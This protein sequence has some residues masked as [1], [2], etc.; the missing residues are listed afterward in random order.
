MNIQ[1]IVNNL[2]F[3]SLA[4]QVFAPIIFSVVDI[5]TGFIQAVI[6]NN[7]SSKV[8]RVGL[9]HKILI[10]IVITTGFVGGMAFNLPII[11][12]FIC[13]YIIIMET[14]SIFENLSKA[15]LDVKELIKIFKLS[16]ASNE[17]ENKNNE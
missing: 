9:L 17:G 16:K 4:W 13:G 1:E 2:D 7:V 14:V 8:M 5:I 11:P 10:V 3:S 12:K 6:N 15:G